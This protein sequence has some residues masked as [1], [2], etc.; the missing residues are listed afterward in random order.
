MDSLAEVEPVCDAV[1]AWLRS[2]HK[3]DATIA[4][5][6]VVVKAIQNARR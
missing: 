6:T 3:T 2:H 4:S 1:P 5:T